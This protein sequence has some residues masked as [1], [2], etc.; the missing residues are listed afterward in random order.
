MISEKL[1]KAINAQIAMELW[2][3]NLYMA[4]S[5]YF[6]RNGFQGC[7]NW[8]RKQALEETEHA[9]EMAGFLTKRG[10]AP[11][12]E[13]IPE[14]T[15]HW[16]SP[17]EAFENIYIHEC[18]ISKRIDDLL[19]LASAEKDNAAQ[20]FF[21]KFVREQV[22]EEATASGIVERMKVAGDNGILYI[23]GQLGRRQ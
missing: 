14:V 5:F 4:M 17:L 10:G 6:D 21:W 22:E 11:V 15:N 1:Q 19:A 12:V 8:T 18:H 13:M 20:D 9:Y 2:S 16:D 3:A 23:D 7:S